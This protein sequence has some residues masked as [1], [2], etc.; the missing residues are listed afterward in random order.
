MV[1]RKIYKRLTEKQIMEEANLLKEWGILGHGYS[2]SFRNMWADKPRDERIRLLK[3]LVKEGRH[4]EKL[5]KL[6][7]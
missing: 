3:E 4:E 2:K 6:G 1:K 7:W 5:K